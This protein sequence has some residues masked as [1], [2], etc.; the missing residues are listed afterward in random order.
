MPRK[1]EN[2]NAPKRGFYQRRISASQKRQL[3][4]E[5]ADLTAE[6]NMLRM[7]AKV[8]LDMLEGIT[9]YT[10]LDMGRLSLLNTLVNTIAR[11]KAKNLILTH[12]DLTLDKLIEA[13]LDKDS[14]EWGQA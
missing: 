2:P 13:E 7:K 4:K 9:F 10:D 8:L 6:L 3:D 12:Q 14:G 11:L 1:I 5:S